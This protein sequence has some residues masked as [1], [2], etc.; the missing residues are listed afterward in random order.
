MSTPFPRPPLS[1]ISRPRWARA[2]LRMDGTFL[3]CV[4]ALATVLELL[5]HF[6]GKGPLAHLWQSPYTIGGVEAHGL[7]TILGALLLRQAAE[8]DLRPWHA[9][10]LAVHLLLGVSNLMFWSSFAALGML[11]LGIATTV[12]HGLF[13]IAHAAGIARA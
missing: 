10:A 12:A 7:A 3:L 2:A 8:D 13:V 1:T 9:S 11:P 6:T 5:G 4:G